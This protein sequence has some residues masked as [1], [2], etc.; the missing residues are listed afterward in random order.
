MSENKSVNT[1]IAM[2]AIGSGITILAAVCT[3]VDAFGA[4]AVTSFG[5]LLATIGLVA[6]T[7]ATMNDRRR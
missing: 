3:A 1:S 7:I 5:L 4:S 6:G 2:L